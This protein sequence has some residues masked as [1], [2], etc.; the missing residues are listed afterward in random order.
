MQSRIAEVSTGTSMANSFSQTLKILRDHQ[1]ALQRR[2]VLHAAVFGSVARSEVSEE[3]DIDILID[4]DATRP[5]G[6]FAYANLKLYINELL[7][8]K[9]DVVNRKTLKPLLRETITRDAVHAF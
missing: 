1:L 3:S 2:G 7:G 8:E 9:A 6:L 4:L 5:I